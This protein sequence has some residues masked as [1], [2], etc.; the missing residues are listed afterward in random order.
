MSTPSPATGPS[1]VW[2]AAY[3]RADGTYAGRTDLFVHEE[4]ARSMVERCTALDTARL[5]LVRFVEAPIWQPA[6]TPPP[7]ARPAEPWEMETESAPVLV[8]VEH[9]DGTRRQLVATCRVDVEEDHRVTWRSDCS[10]CWTLERVL[11]WRELD[12]PAP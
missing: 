3:L 12:W 10:E 9:S 4:R 2:G 11:A 6:S 1:N 5:R 7:P 8:V